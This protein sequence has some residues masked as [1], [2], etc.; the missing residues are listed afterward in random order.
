[1]RSLHSGASA[2][3]QKHRA[4]MLCSSERELFDL[5]KWF[6]AKG[7]AFRNPPRWDLPGVGTLPQS[8]RRCC[9]SNIRSEVRPATLGFEGLSGATS[10]A[11]ERKL[12]R[13][14]QKAKGASLSQKARQPRSA[15]A[16]QVGCCSDESIIRNVA[17]FSPITSPTWLSQAHR[18]RKHG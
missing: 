17:P 18:P 1:M 6:C 12:P 10:V 5:A 14:W 9:L 13:A 11:A 16:T 15:S 2:G 4:S 8:A 7:P 3:T